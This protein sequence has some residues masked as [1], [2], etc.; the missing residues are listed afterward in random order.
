MGRVVR[1]ITKQNGEYNTAVFDYEVV[2]KTNLFN[3]DF[4]KSTENEIA[5]FDFRTKE[6]TS[7]TV[8][9]IDKCDKL[10]Y[11]RAKDLVSAVG[12]NVS[13]IF[14]AFLS[15][16]R[17]IYINGSEVSPY[18]PLLLVL[19][20][21]KIL[22]DTD[23]NV[24]STSGISGKMHV[25][26]VQIPD[27]GAKT[28]KSLRLNIRGQGFY[29]LRN[30]REIASA[31]EFPEIFKKHNDFNL[32]RIELSFNPD[33]D[34]LMGINLKKHDV[35][36][37]Q[38]IINALREVLDDPIKKVRESMKKKQRNPKNPFIKSPISPKEG[39]EKT[40]VIPTVVEGPKVVTAP[41]K[42]EYDITFKTY[43][44]SEKDPLFKYTLSDDK[45]TVYYNVFNTYYADKI[46]IG[47]QGVKI[48]E[49]LDDIIKASIKAYIKSSNSVSSL[50]SFVDE[51]QKCFNKTE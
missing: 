1:I 2:C 32:L 21:N 42:D 3:A 43:A 33:L 6:A 44:G 10:Q 50:A 5:S 38:E 31:L 28:N 48:R 51:L 41:V 22:V 45:I 15:D 20:G 24:E 26:A 47:E 27:Q 8:L 18:D 35:A 46:Q 40:G 37:S 34:D 16:E 13:E 7:G 49:V 25:L 17:H 12:D 30:K 39:G 36:P 11:T 23:V 19:R 9:I 14:R 29:I 4:H